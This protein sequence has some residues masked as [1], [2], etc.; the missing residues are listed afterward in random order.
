VKLMFTSSKR[1]RF[2]NCIDKLDTDS[3]NKIFAKV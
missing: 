1:T 2:P 3:I